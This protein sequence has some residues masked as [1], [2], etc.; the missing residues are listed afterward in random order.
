MNISLA[1]PTGMWS[2]LRQHLLPEGVHDEQAAFLFASAV[3]NRGEL[4]FEAT[5][6]YMLGVG[7]FDVQH[8]EY[9]EITDDCKTRLIKHAHE[10]SVSLIELHSHPGPWPAAFSAYDLHG[11]SETVPH[12]MWRLKGRPYAAIVVARSGFDAMVWPS[13]EAA[14]LPLAAIDA[15]GMTLRPT[16]LTLL[17]AR[18]GNRSF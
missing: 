13:K 2:R 10:H 8:P 12:V 16:N 5:D 6:A 14:P 18:N 3:P 17:G 4:R 9:L 1:L 11:L 7:D 15:D